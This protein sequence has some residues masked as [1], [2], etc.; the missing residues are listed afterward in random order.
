MK[1]FCAVW[2]LGWQEGQRRKFVYRCKMYGVV[3]MARRP[4]EVFHTSTWSSCLLL[5]ALLAFSPEWSPIT[6]TEYILSTQLFFSLK[7]LGKSWFLL[8]LST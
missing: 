8:N 6:D 1:L 3:H 4:G 7:I 5:T 2:S